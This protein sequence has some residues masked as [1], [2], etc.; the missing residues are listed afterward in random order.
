MVAFLI[1]LLCY[2]LWYYFIHRLMHSRYF[3]FIHKVHHKKRNPEY[4]DYYTIHILELPLQSVG[5][6]CPVYFYKLNVAQ[7]ICALLFINLRGIMEHDARC[8]FLSDHHLT[9]HKIVKYNY[10]EY[11]L[12]Y[13]FGT[14]YVNKERHLI[15]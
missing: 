13:L 10:G 14:L 6:I 4:Y 12:D 5:I 1:Y 9:H 2:D 11:W 3:Y 15:K 8:A 7:L